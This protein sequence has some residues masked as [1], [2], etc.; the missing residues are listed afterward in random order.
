MQVPEGRTA[1]LAAGL[2]LG[3][4]R[5]RLGLTM[6]EVENRHPAACPTSKPKGWFP[7]FPGRKFRDQNRK[8]VQHRIE[9]P[10]GPAAQVGPQQDWPPSR[11][12]STYSPAAICNAPLDVINVFP[13]LVQRSAEQPEE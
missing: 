10:C 5:E 13:Q 4:L 6:C 1:I 9:M 12:F 3:S 2:N 8:S 7:V 11:R